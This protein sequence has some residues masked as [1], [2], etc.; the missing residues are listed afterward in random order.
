MRTHPAHPSGYGPV[1]ISI[2][3]VNSLNFRP[4]LFTWPPGPRVMISNVVYPATGFPVKKTG[5]NWSLLTRPPGIDRA[6][7]YHWVPGIAGYTTV[8]I[9]IGEPARWLVGMV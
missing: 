9:I 6:A 7:F 1:T 3:I 2:W 4:I 5:R 8:K